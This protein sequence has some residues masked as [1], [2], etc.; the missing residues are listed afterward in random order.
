MSDK[1]ALLKNVNILEKTLTIKSALHAKDMV[2]V[3][4]FAEA[5]AN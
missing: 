3:E 1:L 5:V 4:A 2:E